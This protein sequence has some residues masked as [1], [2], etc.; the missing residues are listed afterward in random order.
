MASKKPATDQELQDLLTQATEGGDTAASEAASKP[1]KVTAPTPTDAE[2]DVFADLKSQLNVPHSRSS[3]PRISSSTTSI[4]KNTPTSSN[5]ARSSEEKAAAG[6]G[7][8]QEQKVTRPSAAPASG[9]QKNAD[10]AADTQNKGGGWWGG[11]TGL[12]TFATSAVKQAQ[13]A[14]EQLQKNEEAQKWVEQAKGNYGLLRGLG[15]RACI[16]NNNNN[17]N[18]MDADFLHRR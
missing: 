5:S 11:L 14:V 13:G 17:N 4:H 1:A 10:A 18:L 12:S 8:E 7:G 6:T 15:M 16:N 9:S 2:D 3:T